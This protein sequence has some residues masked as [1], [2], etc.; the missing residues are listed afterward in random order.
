MITNTRV[1]V[2]CLRTYSAGF[3]LS[4][5]DG[6][7]GHSG[8]NRHRRH[9]FG[10][11]GTSRDDRAVPYGHTRHDHHSRPKP[12]VIS[13]HD[14]AFVHRLGRDRLAIIETI[15]RGGHQNARPHQNVVANPDRATGGPCPQGRVGTQMQTAS[16]KNTLGI[17]EACGGTDLRSGPERQLS[18]RRY[19]GVIVVV[20]DPQQMQPRS[21]V[22]NACDQAPQPLALGQTNFMGGLNSKIRRIQNIIQ[23]SETILEAPYPIPP[24]AKTLFMTSQERYDVSGRFA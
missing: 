21:R 13:D 3:E 4:F 19:M 24:K 11:D 15:I 18:S 16:C 6:F 8:N 22:Q 5:A 14:I 12:N 2:P 1:F 10:H 20:H 9:I 17:R 23:N 7:G